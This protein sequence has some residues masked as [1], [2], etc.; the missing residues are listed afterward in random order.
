MGKDF[1]DPRRYIYA[2][3]ARIMTCP[4]CGYEQEDALECLRC[5]IVIEKFRGPVDSARSAT[6][7]TEDLPLRAPKSISWPPILWLALVL[8]IGLFSISHF[9]KDDLPAADEILEDLL[10]HPVQT[11]VHMAPFQVEAGEIVYTITPLHAYELYGLVV[12]HHNCGTWWD[13]Y[14]HGLWKDFIN[15]KDLCVLWGS[16]LETGVYRDMRFASDSWT[17]TYSWPSREVGSRFNHT[18]LSNNH[19]LSRDEGVTRSL[20]NTLPGDQVYLRGY[21]AEYSHSNGAF[22]RGTST[23][24]GDTGNGACETI[25][26]EAYE[27]LRK[28]NPFWRTA[29]TA[30]KYLILLSLLL[31]V[32]RFFRSANHPSFV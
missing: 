25:Y 6:E 8:G 30:S 2:G 13:I 31:I 10:R 12:S 27:I 9:L 5:G 14:H 15:V 19:L 17:C 1:Q 29:F 32:I 21:L 16:N 28:G 26:V 3:S 11:P 7:T 23:R 4:K 20:L 22:R 24:R 18:C